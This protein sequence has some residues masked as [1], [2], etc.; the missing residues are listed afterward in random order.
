MCRSNP[1][2]WS[3]G[4]SG[5]KAAIAVIDAGK[6]GIAPQLYFL[7]R[8]RYALGRSLRDGLELLPI[9]QTNRA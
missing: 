5:G 1:L 7:R 9:K 6:L 2:P 4:L 3:I 8:R